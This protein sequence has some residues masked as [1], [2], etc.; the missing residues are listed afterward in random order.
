MGGRPLLTLFHL[1]CE[2]L[3]AEDFELNY[4]ILEMQAL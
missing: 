2:P 3:M 1:K 4:Q